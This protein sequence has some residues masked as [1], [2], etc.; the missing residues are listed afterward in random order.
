[1]DKCTG[2]WLCN[3]ELRVLEVQV[4]VKAKPDA[5]KERFSKQLPKFKVKEDN[6]WSYLSLI[7][8]QTK[9]D[10]KSMREGV[11]SNC[12]QPYSS[13][14]QHKTPHKRDCKLR[15]FRLIFGQLGNLY[16]CTVNITSD[17]KMKQLLIKKLTKV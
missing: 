10:F 4:C 2:S 17:W 11:I 16:I 3:P 1:M 13:Y 9:P 5:S 7:S 15:T 6:S 8:Q 12:P 14:D